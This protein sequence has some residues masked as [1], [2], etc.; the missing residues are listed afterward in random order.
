VLATCKTIRREVLVTDGKGT[1]E[2]LAFCVGNVVVREGERGRGRG[3][4]MLGSLG[5]EL[6]GIEVGE[7]EARGCGSLLYSAKE[8]V[9]V[10]CGRE[11]GTC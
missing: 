10:V 3:G 9:S 8:E 6:D 11:I 5:G 4:E 2:D 1:R 7:E